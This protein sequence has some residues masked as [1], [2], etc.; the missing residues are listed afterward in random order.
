MTTILEFDYGF[1][2]L[3]KDE[4]IRKCHEVIRATVYESLPPNQDLPQ[5]WSPD[6]RNLEIDVEKLYNKRK[7]LQGIQQ[8]DVTVELVS[9]VVIVPSLPCIIDVD[10]AWFLTPGFNENEYFAIGKVGL[11]EHFQI[12]GIIEPW[13]KVK[14]ISDDQFQLEIHFLKNLKSTSN[15]LIRNF[16]IFLSLI[17]IVIDGLSLFS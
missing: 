13:P 6:M 8:I 4:K 5:P 7:V 2:L 1:A 10:F 12:H 17:S 3:S 16:F 14:K 9:R 11:Q 15:K